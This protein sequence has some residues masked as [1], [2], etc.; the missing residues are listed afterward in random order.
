MLITCF[1]TLIHVSIFQDTKPT[2]WTVNGVQRQAIILEPL[3]KSDERIPVIFN[4]HGHGGNMR[5]MAQKDFQKYWPEALIVCPQGLNTPGKTDPE[6]KK[7]GWQKFEGDQS[8]RD[9]H[10]VDAMLKTLREKYS[11]DEKRLYVTGHSNGGGFT[12][13]LWA[14][15]PQVFAAYAPSAAGMRKRDNLT[16]APIMH[17]AG[18]A[19]TV[20]PFE[21]QQRT[22]EAI[23]KNNHCDNAGIRLGPRSTRYPSKTGADVVTYIHPGTH[24][25]P[26]EVNP[27]IVRFFKE[28]PKK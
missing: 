19:D 14:T 7:P 23:R 8:D 2:F 9:L 26:E 10:F 1:L 15:R 6:G 21:N 28:H 18:T 13:L 3:K 12:Y 20:V 5:R 16:P 11:I 25:Y 4:F 24:K 17:I 27:L 22:M